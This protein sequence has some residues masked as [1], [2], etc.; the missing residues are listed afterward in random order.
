[1]CGLV[2]IDRCALDGQL[3]FAKKIDPELNSKLHICCRDPFCD[4]VKQ[5]IFMFLYVGDGVFFR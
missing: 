3:F 5:V 2:Q 1:M 4:S